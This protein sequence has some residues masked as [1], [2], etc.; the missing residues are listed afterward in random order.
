VE[1]V[2]KN[3][4]VSPPTYFRWK[5]QYSGAELNTV[6]KLK[7]LEKENAGSRNWWP[8]RLFVRL[9]ATSP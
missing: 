5:E 4:G 1:D 6:K 7:Q 2:C 8:S 9:Q 3:L